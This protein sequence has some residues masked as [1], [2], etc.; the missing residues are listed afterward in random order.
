MT[1]TASGQL[2]TRNL[3]EI[4]TF[5][6]T[7]KHLFEVVGVSTDSMGGGQLP[8]IKAVHFDDESNCYLYLNKAGGG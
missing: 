3:P 4:R 8:S 6:H 7:Q 2:S 1:E 5:S